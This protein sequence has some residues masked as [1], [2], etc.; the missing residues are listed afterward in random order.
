MILNDRS[1]NFH[2]SKHSEQRKTPKCELTIV[3]S[4]YLI[5][6]MEL[7]FGGQFRLGCDSSS[8]FVSWPFLLR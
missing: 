3:K 4:T 2:L 5:Y 6:T 1:N 8:S 7:R